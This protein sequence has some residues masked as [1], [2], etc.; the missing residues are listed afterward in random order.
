MKEKQGIKWSTSGYVPENTVRSF[1]SIMAEAI[2]DAVTV[3]MFLLSARS[4]LY[5]V[6]RWGKFSVGVCVWIVLSV[7][8]VSS[9]MSFSDRLQKKGGRMVRISVLL[10]G[11]FAFFAYYF[12]RTSNGLVISSGLRELFSQFVDFWNEYYG[13][14]LLT[15][16]GLTQNI[17]AALDFYLLLI[18]FVLFWVAKSFDKKF[19]VGILPAVVFS[20]ELLVGYAPKI[21]GLLLFA[22]AVILINVPHFKLPEFN[23]FPGKKHSVGKSGIFSWLPILMV[24]VLV[25]SVLVN[26]ASPYADKIIANSWYI[27]ETIQKWIGEPKG[28]GS[29]ETDIPFDN[30]NSTS[31]WLSNDKPVFKHVPVITVTMERAAQGNIYLKDFYAGKY[32]DGRW[33]ADVDSFESYFKSKG[34]DPSQVSKE[35]LRR[36][37]AALEKTYGVGNL[38][39]SVFGKHMD[40][41]YLVHHTGRMAVPYFVDLNVENN[42]IQITGEGYY[43]RTGKVSELSADVWYYENQYKDFLEMFENSESPLL[44]WEYDEYVQ[45]Y[46]LDVPSG[47]DTVRSLAASLY[48]EEMATGVGSEN[49]LRLFKADLVVEWMNKNTTY[50]LKLPDLPRGEDAIEYFLRESKMGYCMHY[51]SASVMLLRE[52]GVPSRLVTGYVV[53]RGDFFRAH[54][55]YSARVMDNQAHAWAEIYLDGLGWF[56]VEVTKGYQSSTSDTPPVTETTK[57]NTLNSDETGE[58]EEDTT[59]PDLTIGDATGASEDDT[60]GSGGEDNSEIQGTTQGGNNEPVGGMDP[61]KLKEIVRCVVLAVSSLLLTMV[62]IVIVIKLRHE[63]RDELQRLIRRQKT[64]LAIRLMNRRIYRKLRMTGKIIRF[65]LRDDS[66]G[67]ILKKNYTEISADEWERYMDLVKAASFS[68][69]EFSDEE[70]KFCYEIYRKVKPHS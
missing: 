27:R 10:L 19:I 5:D 60:Q 69:R 48:S 52:M 6:F 42:H 32:V 28:L 8:A 57:E 1:S 3:L 56:P 63:Y 41:Y 38:G 64:S 30:N 23:L 58:S 16:G 36:E 47:L 12:F 54:G 51:A 59:A 2:L 66:Y 9:V 22:F 46:Y 70:V 20:A 49:E 34:I 43:T 44:S 62:T 39:Q 68:K 65:N 4:M 61:E 33:E 50:S 35:V 18:G 21:T 67:E 14:D 29:V 53:H 37:G 17:Y 7:I 55:G 24:A 13:T 25:S 40:I 15:F 11:L 31:E 26:V 45:Q